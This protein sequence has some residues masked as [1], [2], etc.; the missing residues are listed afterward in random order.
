[1]DAWSYK[2]ARENCRED[3]PLDGTGQ[4]GKV[5]NYPRGARIT[6]CGGPSLL[7]A[8]LLI[9]NICKPREEWAAR[10]NA[11]CGERTRNFGI[12]KPGRFC[13]GGVSVPDFNPV[14]RLAGCEPPE[15]RNDFSPGGSFSVGYEGLKDMKPRNYD[16]WAY[17]SY[18][19]ATVSCG[20]V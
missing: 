20:L 10:L 11:P 13:T 17:F 2:M 12:R 8:R 3:P 1:M 16:T 15:E 6:L 5:K 14:G 4:P 18:Q 19:S 9:C 7:S